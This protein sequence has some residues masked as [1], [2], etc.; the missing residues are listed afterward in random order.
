MLLSETLNGQCF[1]VPW[2]VAMIFGHTASSHIWHGGGGGGGFMPLTW[3]QITLTQWYEEKLDERLPVRC[4][5]GEVL[6]V[7][8]QDRVNVCVPSHDAHLHGHWAPCIAVATVQKIMSAYWY[9]YLEHFWQQQQSE[10]HYSDKKIKSSLW[11]Q[12]ITLKSPSSH[13]CLHTLD[14]HIFCTVHNS[15]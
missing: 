15:Q 13:F 6:N 14:N 11:Q 4:F 12:N 10:R 5:G 1:C 2:K 8:T 9:F 3:T 7:G